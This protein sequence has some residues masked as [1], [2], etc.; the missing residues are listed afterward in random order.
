MFGSLS[1]AC[2]PETVHARRKDERSRKI[3]FT[4]VNRSRNKGTK[5]HRLNTDGDA[6]PPLRRIGRWFAGKEGS[7][8]RGDSEDETGELGRGSMTCVASSPASLHSRSYSR[9]ESRLYEI[10]RSTLP[11]F[12]RAFVRKRVDEDERTFDSSTT[13][14]HQP[15]SAHT[16]KNHQPVLP[17]AFKDASTSEESNPE[18]NFPT[19]YHSSNHRNPD[20]K[21][22]IKRLVIKLTVNTS[23]ACE[24][25]TQFSRRRT[26]YLSTRTFDQRRKREVKSPVPPRE[27]Q[28]RVLLT[29]IRSPTPLR[30]NLPSQ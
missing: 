5:V 28:P 30:P 9:S 27:P 29:S 18:I 1:D 24:S 12:V 23:G 7:S 2:T 6:A 4:R 21:L 14:P 16:S 10:K 13:S 17:E 19:A 11:A 8:G 15:S 22:I 25:G 26:Q 20:C 3:G